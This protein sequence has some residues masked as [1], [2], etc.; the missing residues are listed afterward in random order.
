MFS[1]SACTITTG[2]YYLSKPPGTCNVVLAGG[3]PMAGSTSAYCFL[4]GVSS[5]AAASRLLLVALAIA[6]VLLVQAETTNCGS[7]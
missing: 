4:S 6:F 3:F 7:D 2:G 5:I 1:D